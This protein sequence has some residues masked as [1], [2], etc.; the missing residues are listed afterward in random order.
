MPARSTTVLS[1][2]TIV[3]ALWLSGCAPRT[4]DNADTAT[5][6]SPTNTAAPAPQSAPL[7]DPAALTDLLGRLA[8]PAVPGTDKLPLVEGATAG[9]AATLDNFTK[10]LQDNHMIP[11][12]FTAT[13]LAWSDENPGNVVA[14]VN[15]TGP[16][17]EAGGL[18]FPMEFA[19]AVGGWELSR[20]TAD[21]LLVFGDS[22][23]QAM[24]P[25]PAPPTL[26]AP[27]SIPAPPSTAAP[28]STP[29][30]TPTR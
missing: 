3:A 28:T 17:P 20:Q 19:P 30:P 25:A 11:L 21:M 14:S 22:P 10:A 24:P 2:A 27:T 15:A 7:P 13:N 5:T 1:A 18:S 4:P 29:S 6:P 26:P 23:G 9:D 8:D 16:D 12:T